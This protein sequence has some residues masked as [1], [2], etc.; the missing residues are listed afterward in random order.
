[1]GFYPFKVPA[2]SQG[3]NSPFDF[4]RSNIFMSWTLKLQYKET[5]VVWHIQNMCFIGA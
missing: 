3:K 1:M 2:S 5:S 4:Q